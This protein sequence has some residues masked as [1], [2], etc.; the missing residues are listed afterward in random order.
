MFARA[1]RKDEQYA[2]Y[3]LW[4]CKDSSVSEASAVGYNKPET[5]TPMSELLHKLKDNR[6]VRRSRQSG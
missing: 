5:L 4:A 3:V 6:Y 1:L 2:L